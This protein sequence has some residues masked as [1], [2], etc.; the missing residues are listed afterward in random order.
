MSSYMKRHPGQPNTY[1]LETH[2]WSSVGVDILEL[3]TETGTIAYM[4]HCHV[5]EWDSAILPERTDVWTAFRNHEHKWT[6]EE[7]M[8][9][10][11]VTEIAAI[12]AG[13]DL[14]VNVTKETRTTTEGEATIQY[15]VQSFDT[16]GNALSRH[17]VFADEATA[18]AMLPTLISLAREAYGASRV[19][20]ENDF[21]LVAWKVADGSGWSWTGCNNIDENLSLGGSQQHH[22]SKDM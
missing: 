7:D 5:C 17:G 16:D 13:G 20:S 14:Q 1:V 11:N 19:R 15:V 21:D 12:R 22:G 10:V 6:T 18:I 8:M 4:A 9:S 3:Q 2:N